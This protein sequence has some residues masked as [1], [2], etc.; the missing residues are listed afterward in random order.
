MGSLLSVPLQ[1]LPPARQMVPATGR[2]VAA[3]LGVLDHNGTFC[4]S[5]MCWLLL[6]LHRQLCQLQAAVTA[7]PWQWLAAAAGI[8]WHARVTQLSLLGPVTGRSPLR[9]CA[10]VGTAPLVGPGP[11]PGLVVVFARPCAGQLEGQLNALPE[12]LAA[13]QAEYGAYWFLY[14]P[15]HCRTTCLNAAQQAANCSSTD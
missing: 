6:L 8:C 9:H 2:V 5:A 1:Q 13:D 3:Y 15:R 11:E 12:L 14:D 7:L 4:C 10:A